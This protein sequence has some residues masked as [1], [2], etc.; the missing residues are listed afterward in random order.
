MVKIFSPLHGSDPLGATLKQLGQQMFGDKT[1]NLLAQEKLYAA[2]REN[3]EMDNLM[4]KTASGGVQTLGADPLAQAMIIG[5]GYNPEAFGKLGLMGAAT[6]FG[7]TDPRTQNWQVG[8]GQNYDNTAD[9]VNRKLAETTRSNDLASAD[10]RY[11]VDQSQ[12]TERWKHGTIG[13][14]QLADNTRDQAQF[15]ATPKP[16]LNAQGQP[17]FLPQG[18]LTAPGVAPIVSEADQKGT[19]L[20]Q[21]FDN[22]PA[23]DPMQRQVLGAN[24]SEG[25]KTPKNYIIQGAGGQSQRFITYDG[26]T[27]ARDG[28]PLPA[29]GAIIAGEG[30]AS[31]LGLTNST[32]S[33]VQQNIIANNKF[34]NLAQMTR[35]VAQRD[36]MNFGVPGFVKGV[37]Q[38]AAQI[39]QGIAQG[40]GY[41]GAEQM[42]NEATKGAMQSGVDPNLLSGVFDPD[43]SSLHTLSDLMVYAAAEA[44]AGQS[45]RSVSDKDVLFFKRIVGDPQSFLMNQ[46]KYLAKL[47]QIE[48]ILDMN[49]QTLGDAQT[50]GAVPQMSTPAAPIDD[51]VNKYRS[52]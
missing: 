11:G 24:P 4:R 3:A 5:S 45:G 40:L 49:Q 51:L 18:G 46:Q 29:G 23:L 1:S 48:R 12:G 21:N 20:G 41:Q 22:L 37:A 9:V 32:Q 19:L 25:T 2:E 8:T 50:N 17:V 31:D 38:D 26:V 10:R 39:A 33:G 16:A 47:A 6:G 27:N 15:D 44:L 43:L 28:T 34:K 14:D 42:L 7:A 52:R 13:A 36:P 35:E 30:G